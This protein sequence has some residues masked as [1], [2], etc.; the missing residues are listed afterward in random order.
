MASY[1]ETSALAEVRVS[2]GVQGLD[3]ILNGGLPEDHLYLIEGDPG[4]GKTTLALQFLLEARRRGESVLYV[5]LSESM[6]ELRAIAQSH[7]WSLD[8]LEIFEVIPPPESLLPEDQYTVYHPGDV[9]LGNTLKSILERVDRI[10]PSR[11]V[12][13]SLSEIRLLSRDS[14]RYRRQILGLK[15][16]FESR[17]CTTLLLDDRRREDSPETAV[18]SIVHGVIR[19]ERMIRDYGAKRRRL[20]VM[21]LR[22]VKYHDGY[23]D[24]DIRS[25]GLVIYPRMATIQ[26]TVAQTVEGSASGIAELD[27]LLGG[28]LDRGTST[29][30]AGPAG[31]G[32]SSIATQ[33]AASA[34]AR[35]EATAIY[36]FDE[37][38]TTLYKR[39][40][41]LGLDLDVYTREGSLQIIQ[42]DPA[43]LS[44]GDFMH[45]IRDAVLNRGLRVLIID[46]LNGFLNA[47][48]GEQLLTVQLHELLSFLNQQGVVTI[49]IMAQYGIL[50]SSVESPVDVSYLADTVILLRFFEADGKVRK[51]ISVVKK[52]TG[53]HEDTVREL[54]VGPERIL[55]GPPLSDF[56]G[57]LSGVPMYVGDAHRLMKIDGTQLSR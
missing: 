19:L 54:K 56:Q 26:H 29:L 16:F 37:G 23:H 18:L 47:M 12:F 15:Q 4:S 25:G 48:P 34:A 39:A 28:G 55:V 6:R 5:T 36:L 17:H 57:V 22:G 33:Y 8:G 1:S 9:E 38:L 41:G 42:L 32:K 51:A 2:T 10:K 24:Y 21:K 49:M 11:A 30:L 3:M 7:G 40:R 31:S 35:G 14:A 50:G 20:E 45:Q 43:E 53:G 13:D 46:S 52:R 27:E 44:P